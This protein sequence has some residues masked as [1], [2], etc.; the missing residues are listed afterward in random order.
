M[1]SAPCSHTQYRYV[2][3]PLGDRPTLIAIIMNTGV[4]CK[5]VVVHPGNKMHLT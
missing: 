3:V 4:I 1:L 2:A 5:T